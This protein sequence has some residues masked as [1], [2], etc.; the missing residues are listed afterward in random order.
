VASL[1]DDRWGERI[2]REIFGFDTVFYETEDAAIDS[3]VG[4]LEQHARVNG[5]ASRNQ[6][7]RNP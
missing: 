6:M 4:S 2:L 5:S 3:I 1:N 7:A